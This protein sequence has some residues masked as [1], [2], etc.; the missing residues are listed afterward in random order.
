MQSCYVKMLME[1]VEIERAK[2][3]AQ[4]EEQTRAG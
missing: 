4:R 1:S 2:Y 3:E